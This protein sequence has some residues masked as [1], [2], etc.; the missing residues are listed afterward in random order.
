M[1]TAKGPA[2]KS[3]PIQGRARVRERKRTGDGDKNRAE[4]GV[5][6]VGVVV[7]PEEDVFEDT[8]EDEEEVEQAR[9][10]VK[11][12]SGLEP[13]NVRACQFP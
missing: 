5:G 1:R 7:D 11:V 8:A 6:K 9:E 10:R 2:A 12:C 3:A 13:T 4:V